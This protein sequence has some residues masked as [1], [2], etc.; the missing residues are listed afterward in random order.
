MKG[1]ENF[2]GKFSPF[3]ICSNALYVHLVSVHSFSEM[4]G[5]T[6]LDGHIHLGK[7]V[8]RVFLFSFLNK[9]WNMEYMLLT[10]LNTQVLD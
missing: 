6:K 5:E 2:K 9:R 3:V 4:E 8:C 10:T 1:R 7:S